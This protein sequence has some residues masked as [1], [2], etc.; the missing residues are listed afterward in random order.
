MSVCCKA[1]NRCLEVRLRHAVIDQLVVVDSG[2]PQ[3]ARKPPGVFDG[4]T[5]DS[6]SGRR[7]TAIHGWRSDDVCLICLGYDDHILV[8]SHSETMLEMLATD[9]GIAPSSSSAH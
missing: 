3:E 2:L 6:W 1:R 8:F 9:S 7:I 5:R 4:H